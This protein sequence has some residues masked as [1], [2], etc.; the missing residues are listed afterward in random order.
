MHNSES[1]QVNS[2]CGIANTSQLTVHFYILSSHSQF[3]TIYK[4]HSR[5][6]VN[7]VSP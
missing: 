4:S 2:I 7:I 3:W 1:I 5:K 6:S